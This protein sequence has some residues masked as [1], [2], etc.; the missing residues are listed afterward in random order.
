MSNDKP[1]NLVNRTKGARIAWAMYDWANSAYSLVIT[2]A[3]FP[4]YFHAMARQHP[5]A[6]ITA[7]DEAMVPFLGIHFKSIT[8]LSIAFAIAYSVIAVVSPLLSGIADYSGNK[9]KFMMFFCLMGSVSCSLMYFFEADTFYLGW[10]LFILAAIGFA[11]GLIFNDAFLPEVA[12]PKD[13]DRTSALGYSLGYIGSVLL[14]LFN[15][16]MVLAPG[17]YFDVEGYKAAQ[18]ALGLDDAAATSAT[19][20][21]F[22]AMAARV[23]C[24]SV[25]IWWLVF[26]QIT[27]F[28]L[29]DVKPAY[30]PK[31]YVLEGFREMKKVMG[32]L[33]H[34]P[35]LKQYLFAYF[36]FNM[37]L[38]T[39]MLMASSYGSEELHLETTSLI[40][41]VL[42][43]QLIAVPGAFLFA[44]SSKRFGNF[45]TLLGGILIWVAICICAF[46]FVNDKYSFYALGGVVGLVM[47]G[48]QSLAR[49]TYSK[50]VPK[51]TDTA[52]YFSF[53]QITDKIAIIFGTFTFGMVSQFI[54]TRY[55]ILALVFFFALGAVMLFRVMRKHQITE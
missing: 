17:L 16:T 32:S 54:G 13:Y 46:L 39:V 3:I 31:N 21:H 43:I 38:Q 26:A 5:E 20:G 49:S 30:K 18:L 14:L 11:G 55:S 28:K 40:I 35:A 19:E 2:T 33:K 23:S 22:S 7:N 34:L 10:W 52:S 24:L 6:R 29:K 25:G 4:I 44:A 15:L 27:F 42:V 48:M 37:A 50:L 45:K 51:T 9:K 36:C 41:T 12:E 47:G 8:M 53:Y 1:A